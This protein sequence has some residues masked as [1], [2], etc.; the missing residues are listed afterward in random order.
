MTPAEPAIAAVMARHGLARI[1]AI[2][3]I[4]T[5]DHARRH[6]SRGL[7]PATAGGRA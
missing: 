2:R 4:Q 7:P 6:T 5:R 3:H 1:Q